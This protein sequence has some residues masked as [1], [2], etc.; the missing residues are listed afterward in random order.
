MGKGFYLVAV[1]REAF[2]SWYLF[3]FGY[4]GSSLLQDFSVSSQWGLRS[5]VEGRP[6]SSQWS[7]GSRHAGFST[8]RSGLWSTGSIV[9]VQGLSCPAAYGILPDQGSNPS[10]LRWQVDSL[11]LSYEESLKKGRLLRALLLLFFSHSVVSDSA[12][13]WTTARQAS[14]S[15]TIPRVCS[16]LCPLSW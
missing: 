4:A 6:L 13:P 12:T 10:L 3:V 5:A 9:G 1:L 15:F 11:P 2:F 16:D 14:L 8:C 7:T